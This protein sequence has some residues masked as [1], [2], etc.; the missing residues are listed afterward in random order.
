MYG[1]DE[2]GLGMDFVQPIK[3]T[4]ASHAGTTWPEVRR[5][6]FISLL[7]L[8]NSTSMPRAIEEHQLLTTR[9]KG[10]NIAMDL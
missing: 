8:K 1:T 6:M 7:R 9:I 4:L 2:L 10:M 3:A 5:Y